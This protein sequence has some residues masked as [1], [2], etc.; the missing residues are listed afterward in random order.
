MLLYSSMHASHFDFLTPAFV[1]R[2]STH[3]ATIAVA[4]TVNTYK[5]VSRALGQL[6]FVG[7]CYN[8]IYLP[9]EYQYRFARE[10]AV[11][12]T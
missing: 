8:T 7:K 3:A 1:E 11:S 12:S 10:L 6:V 5:V 4:T 9:V 2:N